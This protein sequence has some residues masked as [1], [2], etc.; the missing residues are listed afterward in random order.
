MT[1]DRILTDPEALFQHYSPE[2]RKHFRQRL[3]DASRDMTLWDVEAEI[4]R[5]DGQKRYT[6]ALARPHREPDGS[7]L[8][9]GVILDATRIKESEIAASAAEAR[10]R[11]AIVESLSQAFCCSTVTTG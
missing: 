3:L 10:T 2:Y 9:T 4:N 11:Q 1:A 5:P 7:V 6:H 8:W